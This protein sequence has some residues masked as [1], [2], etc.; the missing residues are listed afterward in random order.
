MSRTNDTY[1]AA[2]VAVS[3]ALDALFESTQPG[4]FDPD[5][6]THTQFLHGI[7]FG[8]HQGVTDALA[9]VIGMLADYRRM[10]NVV[11]I[12]TPQDSVDTAVAFGLELDN[13]E[14]GVRA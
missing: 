7:S 4:P 10:S 9:V 12:W 5:A 1:E 11:P 3:A 13:A 2:L 8:R 14:R 6:D